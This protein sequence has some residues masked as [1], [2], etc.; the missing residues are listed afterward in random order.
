MMVDEQC[1]T[2]DLK[3]IKEDLELAESLA[4]ASLMTPTAAKK[5]LLA[6]GMQL[7]FGYMDETSGDFV[8]PKELLLYLVR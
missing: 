8:P 7:K 6:R 3:R 4:R 1:P 5:R 2:L